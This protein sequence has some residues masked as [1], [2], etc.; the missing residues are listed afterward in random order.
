MLQ[1]ILLFNWIHSQVF[2]WVQ[3]NWNWDRCQTSSIWPS[4]GFMWTSEKDLN[5]RVWGFFK[6][7]NLQKQYLIIGETESKLIAWFQ[8]RAFLCQLLIF[9]FYIPVG[10]PKAYKSIYSHGKTVQ[11]ELL[12]AVTRFESF[13]YSSSSIMHTKCTFPS[14]QN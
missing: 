14:L 4:M 11:G 3:W 5:V 7:A 8:Q 2:I 12:T 13:A 9:L 1:R 6:A 10:H